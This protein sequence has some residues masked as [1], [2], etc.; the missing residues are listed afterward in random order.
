MTRER[1]TSPV[2]T[3]VIVSPALETVIL[4]L[5]T[6]FPV[7]QRL[8]PLSLS[9][10]QQDNRALLLD[11]VAPQFLLLLYLQDE[12][13]AGGQQE[14]PEDDVVVSPSP[15]VLRRT[16]GHTRQDHRSIA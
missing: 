14:E 2:Y 10:T 8:P 1:D 5:E 12:H 9:R 4:V 7:L 13:L 11:I 3:M 15:L 6:V 16:I